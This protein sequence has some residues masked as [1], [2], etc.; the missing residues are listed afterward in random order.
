MDE[1]SMLDISDYQLKLH[2]ENKGHKLE[3]YEI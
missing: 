3:N 1:M 2:E